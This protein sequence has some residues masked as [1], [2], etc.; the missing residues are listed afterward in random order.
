MP[1][2]LK[3]NF[4][5]IRDP[6][7]KNHSAFAAFKREMKGKQYGEE[8]LNTAWIWFRAGWETYSIHITKNGH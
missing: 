7:A 3:S 5:L 1:A 8:A 2:K 6:G 4:A